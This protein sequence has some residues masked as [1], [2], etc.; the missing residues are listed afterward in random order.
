MEHG[1]SSQACVE[2]VVPAVVQKRCGL[3]HSTLDHPATFKRKSRSCSFFGNKKTSH[4]L[5]LAI[6]ALPETVWI[7]VLVNEFGYQW[8]G[9][10]VE[11]AWLQNLGCSVSHAR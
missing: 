8:R 7:H 1:L 6:L 2:D 4:S 5:H 9:L 3:R 10:W 11:L